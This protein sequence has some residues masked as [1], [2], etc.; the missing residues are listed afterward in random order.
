MTMPDA[1]PNRSI[2]VVCRDGRE[3][4][5]TLF[6]HASTAPRFA[7]LINGAIGVQQRFYHPV[8]RH[9]ATAGAV[10]LT[11]DYRGIGSSTHGD[12]KHE[13]GTLSDWGR[14]D[15]V[16]AIDYLQINRPGLPLCVLGHSAGGQLIGLAENARRIRAVWCVGS[17]S[18]YWGHWPWHT[19][20]VL[21]A[22]WFV[23]VPG[24][25]RLL[26]RFPMRG[27]GLGTNDLPRQVALQWAKW[28]RHP[29]Y[30]LDPSEPHPR[31]GF[32]DY[33]GDLKMLCL[34]D[35]WM[36]PARS[37]K[38]LASLYRNA[39]VDV[40]VMQSRGMGH[41]G[42]FRSRSSGQ[43]ESMA[44]WLQTRACGSSVQG[45]DSAGRG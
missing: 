17:Q 1:V 30:L 18:G 34:S 10:V 16:A 35:D 2:K 29:G 33:R 8:A 21:A 45:T 25:T 38:A 41:F 13:P 23:I 15:T 36:A 39:N 22:L 7:V 28:C 31:P 43:W 27:L 32:D 6:E 40:Q 19:R 42:F 14:L 44:Q 26:G 3:L 9:L 20:P 11:Y 37:V 4:S 5:G 12:L 24:L